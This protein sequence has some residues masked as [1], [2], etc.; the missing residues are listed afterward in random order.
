MHHGR[1][2]ALAPGRREAPPGERAHE[3]LAN[4]GCVGLQELRLDH[5]AFRI[6]ETVCEDDPAGS[7]E[8]VAGWQVE[9]G[10][11]DG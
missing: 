8:R 5:P 9:R 7:A 11:G 10:R 1:L 6:D 4:R 3:R 2:A